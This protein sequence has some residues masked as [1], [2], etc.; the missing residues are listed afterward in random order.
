MFSEEAYKKL[1]EKKKLRITKTVKCKKCLKEFEVTFIEGHEKENYYCSSNC[2]HSRE[3]TEEIN[4][5]RSH[6]TRGTWKEKGFVV[7][8]EKNCPICGK[9]FLSKAKTCSYQCNSSLR[10]R[11]D[12]SKKKDYKLACQ[13]RFALNSF[14]AEFDFTLVEEHGWYKATNRGGDGS[15]ISRDHMLSVDFG[16]K[17]KIDPSIIRHPANCKLMLHTENF[18]KNTNCSIT[19][20]DLLKRIEQWNM[21]YNGVVA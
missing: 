8:E 10:D 13:F 12:L 19:L 15:G 17:N 9:L 16:W 3:Q 5:R 1:C 2:S 7:K 21:K 18:K 14:P 4:R 20:E 6:T 11:K